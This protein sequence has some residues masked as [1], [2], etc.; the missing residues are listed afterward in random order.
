MG[1]VGLGY[2]NLGP[3]KFWAVAKSTYFKPKAQKCTV[4]STLALANNL[5]MFVTLTITTMRLC[6]NYIKSNY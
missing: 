5:S 3:I 1:W 2:E 6:L 4:L